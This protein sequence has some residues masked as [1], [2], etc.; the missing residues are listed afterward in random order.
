MIFN[1][2]FACLALVVS[3]ALT[4]GCSTSS[5]NG[6]GTTTPSPTVTTHISAAAGGT[7]AD[8]AGTATLTIPGGALAGDLDITLATTA[9]ESGTATSVVYNFGPEGT[10]FSTPATLVLKLPSSSAV[11]SG[12]TPS[13]ATYD[14]T[15]WA[16]ITGSTFAN[17]AV[18]GPVAH[19][20]KFTIVFI[21]GQVVLQSSCG[22]VVANFV[23]C[24]GDVTGTWGF[25][26]YC[27]ENTTIGADPTD[28]GCPGFLYASTITPSGTFTFNTGGTYSSST[29]A[30]SQDVTE[31]IPTTCLGGEVCVSD[32][33]ILKGG[34]CATTGAN[35]VCTLSQSGS[36]AAKTGSYSVDSTGDTITIDTGSTPAEYCIKGNTLT[37]AG[38]DTSDGG[39][40]Q[41]A[42][43]FVLTK[44]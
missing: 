13:L 23:K 31:T 18:S 9:A 10:K 29:L 35:C 14:G 30:L 44:Q 6:P 26:D 33:G 32:G 8:A 22:D 20:S 40:G 11:P 38:R 24:G 25:T 1:V 7:V 5:S 28:G 21:N 17:G 4:T 19:F 41:I 42:Q 16:P 39:T 37:I 34:T 2:R 43:A 27:I 3:A 12:M 15:K 36:S